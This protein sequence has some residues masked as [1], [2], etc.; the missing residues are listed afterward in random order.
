MRGSIPKS[1][2]KIMWVRQKKTQRLA[3]AIKEQDVKGRSLWADAGKR[4]LH[5]KAAVAGLI[6]LF[7]V[8]IFAFF[9]AQFSEFTNDEIDFA[10]IGQVAELG[11]PSLSTGHYFG[12]DDL[13]RDL[14]SRVIQGTQISLMVGIV[15]AAI[16][17]IVGTLYGAVAGYAGGR[18]DNT[19]MR[20]VDMLMAIPYMFV[21]IL[22]LVMFGRSI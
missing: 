19:M 4:F 8:A 12:T 22:L 6:I 13:G 16:A 20:I 7:L 10:V 15:G 1:G 11:G 2:I 5:N 9:G 18:T 14:F 21:I 3:D 17:V